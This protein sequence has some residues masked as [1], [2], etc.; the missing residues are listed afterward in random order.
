MI[1]QTVLCVLAACG[2]VTVLWVFLGARLLPLRPRRGAVALL[3]RAEGG[4][5][6]FRRTYEALSWLRET[7]LGPQEIIFWDAGLSANARA[8][9]EM[10]AR[11]NA[12]VR[13]ADGSQTLETVQERT[14]GRGTDDSPGR[15]ERRGIPE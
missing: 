10:I 15:G 11:S 8:A 12:G 1:G 7:G 5:A 6:A 14:H 3:W 13:L 9:A 2:L 4:E